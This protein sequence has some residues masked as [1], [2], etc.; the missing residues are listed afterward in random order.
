[1]SSNTLIPN[2]PTTIGSWALLIAK[3][4]ESYGLSPLE[5][6]EDAA[7]D[8]ASIQ[9]NPDIRLPVNQM[10]VLWNLAVER[11]QDPCFSLRLTKY[12]Q[13]NT[14]SAVGL[15]MASSSNVLEG[16]KRCLRFT[17]MT[18]DAA[19]LSMDTSDDQVALHLDIPV[20]HQPVAFEA[21]EAFS[22]TMISLFRL[23]T[24]DSF[25][26]V[27]VC[28][29]HDKP[30]GVAE[31]AQFFQCEVAFSQP[32]NTLI[33]NLADI[34]QPQMLANP[35]LVNTLE[36]WIVEHMARF[37]QD[38][39]STQVKSYILENILLE[40]V[41]LEQIASHLNLGLR[42]LQRK[43]K[44]EGKSFNELLD[45]CRHHLALKLLTEQRLPLIE[46]SYMLGF[47]DQSGFTRAFKR[48]TNQSPKHYRDS[49][50]PKV[51]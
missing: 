46:I 28:Y 41:D 19:V 10:A 47:A 23:M 5:L 30:V 33:F 31:F 9:Q 11:T 18:T 26:P 48:W 12:F 45:E 14:Y 17:Q 20:E 22:A 3:A 40:E 50:N 29:C 44:A 25:A 4:I 37:S 49:Q 42:T 16:L 6:F 43:L 1:M 35:S 51:I 38:L 36:A 8:L 32:R 13:P 27:S 15:A 2:T 34:L 39:V 21:V 7:L 24:N